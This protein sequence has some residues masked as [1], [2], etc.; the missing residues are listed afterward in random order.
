MSRYRNVNIKPMEGDVVMQ[1]GRE[2]VVREVR[3]NP[4]LGFSNCSFGNELILDSPWQFDFVRRG[5]LSKP[6]NQ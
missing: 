4:K 3:M 1:S 2:V 5:A 6:T